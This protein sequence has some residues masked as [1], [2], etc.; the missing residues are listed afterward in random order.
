MERKDY[1]KSVHRIGRLF[2][3]IAI[4]LICMVP[5]AYCGVSGAEVEW[6]RLPECLMFMVGY[7]AI[8]LVEALSYAPLL[9][10]GGQYLTFI[11]GNISNLKLPCALN[12]QSVA[13]CK[14]GSEEK[15]LVTTISIAVCSIVTTLVIV[16]GLVP[17]AFYQEEILSVL[18][19]ISPYVIPAIFGGLTCVLFSRYAKIA[20]VPFV[21]CLSVS[22]VA[23]FF[24]GVTIGQSAMIFIGMIVSVVTSYLLLK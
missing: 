15:E 9:G 6:G 17:L 1:D 4:G 20:L 7:F 23:Y 12:A 2:S 5:V 13:R 11:T 24:F 10:I 19:P 16:I 3:W 21:I 8:G 14:D 22:L 18:A